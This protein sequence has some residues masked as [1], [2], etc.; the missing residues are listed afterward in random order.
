M[1]RGLPRP[2]MRTDNQSAGPPWT[3][4]NVRGPWYLLVLPSSHIVSITFSAF[5]YSLN[6]ELNCHRVAQSRGD[7][8]KAGNGDGSVNPTVAADLTH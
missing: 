8:T 6:G 5:A 2:R 3:S 7:A 1:N 4:Y